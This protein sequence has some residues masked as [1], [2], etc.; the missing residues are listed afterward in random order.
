M[1]WYKIFQFVLM[2]EVKS[3]EHD[4]L[5]IFMSRVRHLSPSI[6]CQIKHL[7]PNNSSDFSKQKH[8]HQS[9]LPFCKHSQF[10]CLKIYITF[11]PGGLLAG[12]VKCYQYNNI[13]IF[14]LEKREKTNQVSNISP[15]G[16][17]SWN[18]STTFGFYWEFTFI[19]RR[20]KW[21]QCPG[22]SG[23]IS[24]I[25]IKIRSLTW[26]LSVA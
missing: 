13:K 23:G 3:C 2:F 1:F 14:I 20:N 16:K 18:E 6:S 7:N 24:R 26:T 8:C 4:D 17:T 21:L 25:T 5:H 12:P 10:Y 19:F 15:E 22:S 9:P 11:P